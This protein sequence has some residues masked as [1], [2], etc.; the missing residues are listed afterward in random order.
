VKN[1]ILRR[2]LR[3]ARFFFDQLERVA[4]SDT[5]NSEVVQHFMSAF[6]SSCGTIASSFRG[7]PYGGWYRGWIR[8]LPKGDQRLVSFMREQR[9]AEVHREGADVLSVMEY[10]AVTQVAGTA[11]R[12]RELWIGRPGEPPPRRSTAVHMLQVGP[13]TM[14]L[15]SACARYIE[16]LRQLVLRF[17]KGFPAARD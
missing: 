14:G 2:K 10:T 9:N 12:Q 15:V 11:R 4:R 13:S 6:L 16:L 3:E 1:S 7:R 17:E 8:A 5:D